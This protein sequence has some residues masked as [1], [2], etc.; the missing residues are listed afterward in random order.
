MRSEQAASVQH[1]IRR[2]IPLIR[3]RSPGGLLLRPDRTLYGLAGKVH[4]ETGAA[5]AS[6]PS[7]P[8]AKGSCHRG[9][10]GKRVM[11]EETGRCWTGLHSRPFLKVFMGDRMATVPESPTEQSQNEQGLKDRHTSNGFWPGLGAE[12]FVTLILEIATIP[13]SQYLFSPQESDV[14]LPRFQLM[15]VEKGPLARSVA[16]RYLGTISKPG[17]ALIRKELEKLSSE[18]P[19]WLSMESGG[20]D[21]EAAASLSDYINGA[22][23]G[24]AIPEK[25][26][27][28]SAC[29]LMYAA[30]ERK[31]ASPNAYFG[32][33][34][35]VKSKILFNFGSFTINYESYIPTTTKKILGLFTSKIADQKTDLATFF[36]SCSKGN[37]TYSRK[38][39]YLSWKQTTM[40]VQK[41]NGP[42]CDVIAGQDFTWLLEQ[43]SPL[44]MLST[45]TD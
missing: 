8:L 24:L 31:Y 22:K 44:Q 27:C 37:P 25:A 23:I 45:G 35:A 40:I 7:R 30:A 5:S 38:V 13:G 19:I 21:V 42:G 10:F 14:T 2:A 43:V 12:V 39:V 11:L 16:I 29:T 15:P 20:G 36:D 32:F 26:Q 18:R 3:Q 33:H 4:Q 28:A 6:R 34:Y 17:V 1:M 9:Q 41:N